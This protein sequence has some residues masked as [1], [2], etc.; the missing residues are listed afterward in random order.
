MKI[1]KNILVVDNGFLAK[2]G[3]RYFANYETNEFFEDLN[4]IF[5]HVT[6]FQFHKNQ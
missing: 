3:S 5:S 1:K 6:V 2:E 4:K